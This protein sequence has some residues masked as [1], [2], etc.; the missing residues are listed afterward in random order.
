M[1]ETK[2]SCFWQNPTLGRDEL[3]G[4]SLHGHTNRSK[5]SLY[6]IPQLAKKCPML[7]EA[8]DKKCAKSPC[9]VDFTRAY[10]T[11]PLNPKMAYDLEKNQIAKELG[12][13]SLVSLTD[14]DSIE[15]PSVLRAMPETAEIPLSL[16]WSVPFHGTIFHLGVHNLPAAHAAAIVED[17]TAYRR[18][19]NDARLI[20]LLAGLDEIP[21][22][23]VV[24]NHPLWNQDDVGGKRDGGL[25]DRFLKGHA[26]FL[27]AIE[28]NATRR[29]WEN[30]AA[31]QI[32][33]R[34]K[35]PLVSGGDRHGCEAS[36]ALNVT[37]AQSFDEFVHE[38]RREKHSHIMVMTQYNAPHGLRMAR[39][40]LDVIRDYPDFPESS[41]RWDQRVYY[42]DPKT[43]VPRP[44]AELWKAPPSF[45]ER[46][47]FGIRLLE[48]DTVQR[49][50]RMLFAGAPPA[51]VPFESSSEAAS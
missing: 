35:L 51:A 45:V 1:A 36:G 50:W 34:W 38:I 13:A 9:G 46:I 27:H 49:A 42:P 24:F 29:P 11:P 20:E 30:K 10:W 6:F 14:H 39:T 3:T 21:D 25:L 4:V 28:F 23:M 18:S 2:L 33:T 16:E 31:Q 47:F 17:L 19:P 37:K 44:L 26:Q 48:H 15:A 22:V 32:A 41:R 7:S 43:D 5:E 40:L 8:L 12:L